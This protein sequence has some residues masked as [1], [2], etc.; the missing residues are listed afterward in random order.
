MPSLVPPSTSTL[1]MVV[2]PLR[3]CK[4][5]K[6]V[7]TLTLMGSKVICPMLILATA[8]ECPTSWNSTRSKLVRLASNPRR[9]S[10]NRCK[11]AEFEKLLTELGKSG[12]RGVR[13]VQIGVCYA[14]VNRPSSP[15][16]SKNRNVR[17]GCTQ[18]L[19]VKK[20]RVKRRHNNMIKTPYR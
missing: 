15:R 4:P 14:D 11:I 12:M 7:V 19:I 2:N 20:R 10:V 3:P 6:F 8:R 16:L 13:T 9:V 1:S 17:L 18:G 5:F